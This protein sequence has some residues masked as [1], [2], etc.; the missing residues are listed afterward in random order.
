M[1]KWNEPDLTLIWLLPRWE[2]KILQ[3]WAQHVANVVQFHDGA[4]L[5]YGASSGAE[6]QSLMAVAS[7]GVGGG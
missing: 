4:G 1:W 3:A 6:L 7:S 5:G 2:P